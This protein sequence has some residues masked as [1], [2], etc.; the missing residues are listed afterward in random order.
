MAKIYTD[1]WECVKKKVNMT[2]I[3]GYGCK[4]N[5][6]LG[7]KFW[8]LFIKEMNGYYVGKVNNILFLNSA[9]N[10]GDIVMFEKKH[11]FEVMTPERRD[12]ESKKFKKIMNEFYMVHKRTPTLIEIES[13]CAK[14]N[15]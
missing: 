12:L 11:I 8:V 2:I 9:Y 3:R 5:N 7:E 4:I 10:I 6:P 15:K 14:K 13:I 1:N